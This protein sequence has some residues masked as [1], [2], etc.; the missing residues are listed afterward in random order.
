MEDGKYSVD[1]LSRERLS[2]TIRKAID[3]LEITI[4]SDLS[5][6]ESSEICILIKNQSPQ[7]RICFALKRWKTIPRWKSLFTFL[8]ST[9]KFLLQYF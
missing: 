4:E 8:A 6:T 2:D 5:E 7:I 9:L 1:D 3:D